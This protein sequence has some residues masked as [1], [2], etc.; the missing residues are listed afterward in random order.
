MIWR[1][2][3]SLISLLSLLWNYS[4][5]Q[6]GP[7]CNLVLSGEVIDQHDKS[8]LSFATVYLA[9][10]RQGVVADS[11]GRFAIADLCPGFYTLVIRHVSCEPDTVQV[12]LTRD[13]FIKLYLEHH[14]DYLEQIT[15]TGLHLQPELPSDQQRTLNLN[16]LDRFSHQSL[17]DVLNQLPG[18]SSLKTGNQIVKPVIQGLYGSRVVTINNG[19][20]MQDMEWGDEH[21]SMIDINTAGE[22]NVV[23]GGSALRYGGDAVAGLILLQ[24]EEI[25]EDTL[26]ARTII[27]GATNGRGGSVTSDLAKGWQKGW[28]TKFQG[29]LKR[30]GD[31]HAPDYQLTNTGSYHK[32]FSITAGRVQQRS[33]FDAYYSFY[34]SEIAILSASHIGNIRDLMDAINNQEP[35]IIEDFSYKIEPPR[36]HIQH[37]IARFQY[38]H[39]T[40]TG[41]WQLQYDY[42]RNHR[43]EYDR[44]RGDNRERPSIDLLLS[45]H[46]FSGNVSW[47]EEGPLPLQLGLMY[48]YQNHF[49]NPE[50]GVRR[51]IP[52]YDKHEVGGYLNGRYMIN[53]Q[54][55][56]DAG[57]R[58]DFNRIDAL[59]F[60]QKSRWEERGYQDD[61]SHFVVRELSTQ[62]L[63]NPIFDYHNV[64][65]TT[66]VHFDATPSN[67]LK[68][69]YFFSRRAPNPSE[70]FSDGLHHGA[71]RIE[72]GDLR[73]QP[74]NSHKVGLAYNG[75]RGKLQ[76]DLSSYLSV[77]DDFVL[78]VPTGVEL[79]LRGVFPVWE[80]QQTN[81]FM[82]GLDGKLT[83]NWSP[84]WQTQHMARYIH[85]QDRTANEPLINVPAPQLNNSLIY[86]N[87]A[88]RSFSVT[89]E[90]QY[91]FQQQR[92]PDYNF[93]VFVPETDTFEELDLS[94]P[95]DAY[96]LINIHGMSQIKKSSSLNIHLGLSINNVFNTKYRD[97]LNRLRYFADEVGRSFEVSLKFEY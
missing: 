38:N 48:R 14:S 31:F 90:S 83:A 70:L 87:D 34:D 59:K 71:A 15:I 65:Y 57:I 28:Y 97:Y 12:N 44:R 52:D 1:A 30:F 9:N 39:S 85:G 37:Q 33:S 56:I 84:Q 86:K 63:T 18:V 88:W 53:E 75:Y 32:G 29:S 3:F 81:A 80:Y 92:F 7:D 22:V 42:Q 96:H 26:V 55:Q 27:S 67:E 13:R 93:E 68:F 2:S 91:T 47:N 21:A 50:T 46:T 6:T 95:P 77:I 69:N 78:L 10:T 61:F 36:Q 25:H 5:A 94:T 82:W 11:T 58:Y 73:I 41:N 49:A 40:Q 24:P 35:G 74:E 60:Y 20:R 89:L 4:Q 79:T 16:E 64:S 8:E 72:L 43:F 17:G 54:W 76:W 19:V 51:L 23:S 62:L 66:G 45:T